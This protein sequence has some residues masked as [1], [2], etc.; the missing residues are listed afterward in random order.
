MGRFLDELKHAFAVNP[1]PDEKDLDLPEPLERLAKSVVERGM[2]TPAIILLESVRPLSFLTGQA[3]VAA[4]PLVKMA[5][6]W[7]DYSQVADALEDRRTV[8]ILASRIEAL[9]WERQAV[10]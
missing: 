8:Q 2:E 4:W 9:A 3:M 7:D 5:A 10:P 6:N 1:D